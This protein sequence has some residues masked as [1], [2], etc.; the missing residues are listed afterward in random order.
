M[1]TQELD[2]ARAEAFAGQFVGILNS[3]ALAAM[4]SVGHQTGL[5]DTMAGLPPSTSH[6]IA[7]ATGLNERYV[8]EWLG[9]MVTGRIIEY[10]GSSRT[11]S[12]PREHAGFLTR[13]AGPDN[14]ASQTQYLALMGNVEQQ[15]I[16]SFRPRGVK[17]LRGHG[18][19]FLTTR[20]DGGFDG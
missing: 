15:I 5:F 13:A 6:E 11:Y 8:R 9:A 3:A 16:E 7:Q 19:P 12:L 10:D 18:G 4:A 2:P 1:T 17:L 14:L 20:L